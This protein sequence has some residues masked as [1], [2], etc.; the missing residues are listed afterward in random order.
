M[1]RFRSS[2][3]ALCVVLCVV[4]A[5]RAAAGERYTVRVALVS[6]AAHLHNKVIEE[7]A[8]EAREKTGGK[9]T[10]RVMGSSQLGGERDY[11][12]G[13]QLGNIEMAQ[14]SSGPIS[15]FLPDFILVSLPYF[16]TDYQEMEKVFNGPVG[17][18]LFKKLDS[19][20]MKG[21]T[22]FTNGFR[23]VYTRNKAIKT[24]VDLKGLKIRVMESQVMIS[25]LNHMGASATPMAYSELYAAIQQGVMDGAE[26]ALGNI[27]ADKY[28]EICKNVSLTG[29]FA[30]PGVVA[31]SRKTFDKLPADIQEYLV[32]SAQ[33][34]G[35][36]QR[37]RDALL[38]KEMEEKL[39]GLGMT[40][41]EVDKAAFIEAT[42]P[43]YGEMREKIDPALIDLV[44]KNLGKQ[45]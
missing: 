29:H 7:W 32:E 22:W 42:K 3:L 26:N 5:S 28:N 14:V 33:R 45:F 35:K 25:T 17:E 30:P 43:V 15:G 8:K 24:P 11:L 38:Q 2:V 34:F 13:M 31:I 19:I 37:E 40:I 44:Q 21:L 27:F 9:L 39:A 1:Q 12:E 6:S 16:F 10:L 41:N 20:N 23:N 36:I 18:A 4:A